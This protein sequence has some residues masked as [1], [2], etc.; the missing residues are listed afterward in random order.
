MPDSVSD[1]F[2]V[3]V[4]LLRRHHIDML[5]HE[6]KWIL[7]SLDWWKNSTNVCKGV[8]FVSPKLFFTLVMDALDL[9]CR[10]HL[11]LLQMQ[12]LWSTQDLSLHINIRKL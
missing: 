4:Y 3:E 2:K 11:G 9:G 6:P 10:A 12:G 8:L 5:V 7:S 1:S